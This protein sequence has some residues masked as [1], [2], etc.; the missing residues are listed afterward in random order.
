MCERLGDAWRLISWNDPTL[1]GQRV[2]ESSDEL[3]RPAA[4]ERQRQIANPC[5]WN[6]VERLVNL[7]SRSRPTSLFQVL[8][9]PA[10]MTLGECDFRVIF[11]GF[12][13]S[14][15]WQTK[16]GVSQLVPVLRTAKARAPIL[17]QDL[18]SLLATSPDP[19]LSG[20]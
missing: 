3:T 19:S 15:G 13:L 2:P 20:R 17:L 1:R 9:L 4:D 7:I 18:H 8:A 5:L 6:W 12:H 16:R 11:Q 14:Y 10:R